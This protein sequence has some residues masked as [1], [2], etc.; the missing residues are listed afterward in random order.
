MDSE[1]DPRDVSPEVLEYVTAESNWTRLCDE[2]D[3]KYPNNP[4]H[5]G[6]GSEEG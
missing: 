2:W 5:G 1:P 6:Q 3:K 4:V